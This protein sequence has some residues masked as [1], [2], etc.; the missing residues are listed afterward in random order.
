[1][2]FD[3]AYNKV[4]HQ[5]LFEAESKKMTAIF[6]GGF[7][8]PHKGHF[9]LAHSYATN[10]LIETVK[11]LLGPTERTSNDGS[12]VIGMEQSKLI[13]EQYYLPELPLGKVQLVDMVNPN[14]MRQAFDYIQENAIEN[15]I[16]TLVSSKKDSK[17]AQRSL[18]FSKKHEEGTGKYYRQGVTVVHHPTDT[19]AYYADRTDTKNDKAISASTMREDAAKGDVVNFTTNIPE[20]V[21]QYSADILNIITN[22]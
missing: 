11:I 21:Q 1:M 3:A 2:K 17:D 13:W 6:P 7:K 20:E 19:V 22:E 5:L 9:A 14:P 10:P 4:M 12:V 15:E 16:V 18:D 8:P